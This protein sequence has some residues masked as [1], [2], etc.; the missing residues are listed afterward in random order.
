MLRLDL[1]PSS[2][3]APSRTS[4]RRAR[5]VQSQPVENKDDLEND[6][7]ELPEPEHED[8]HL[9]VRNRDRGEKTTPRKRTRSNSSSVSP[10]KPLESQAAD[11]VLPGSPKRRRTASV[12]RDLSQDFYTSKPPGAETLSPGPQTECNNEIMDDPLDSS[13]AA[14]I[15]EESIS[16]AIEKIILKSVTSTHS[17]VETVVTETVIPQRSRRRSGTSPRGTPLK[18][19]QL[20]LTRSPTRRGLRSSGTT[21]AP[22]EETQ[23]SEVTDK[24]RE[25]VT[26]SVSPMA[27]VSHRKSSSKKKGS[28]KKDATS[29]KEDAKVSREASEEHGEG[30]FGIRVSREDVDYRAEEW[31]EDV[32]ESEPFYFE[33]DH[34]AIKGNKE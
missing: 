1:L 11:P 22:L 4:P 20:D 21:E 19:S 17:P 9:I 7:K 6:S 23:G 14:R 33:S 12:C 24:D 2:E 30:G 10:R 27:V 31:Y 26:P 18:Q 15:Q 29:E 25:E 32:D 34:M 13:L 8:S 3:G 28:S 5:Q 16:D